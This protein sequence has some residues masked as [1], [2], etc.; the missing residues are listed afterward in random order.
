MKKK[1][2]TTLVFDN[3][4][5]ANGFLAYWLD[6]GGDGGGNLDW[7]TLHEESSDWTK[8][9][10]SLLRIKGTGEW[11][12]END[13]KISEQDLFKKRVAFYRKHVELEE[14]LNSAEIWLAEHNKK[15]KKNRMGK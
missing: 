15:N 7:Q 3:K 8:G 13:N 9:D 1:Y 5:S 14:A 4:D 11:R 10:Y 2:E 12:D 6:G